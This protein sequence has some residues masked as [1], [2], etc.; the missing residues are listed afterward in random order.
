VRT[1]VGLTL[2]A[3]SI[4]QDMKTTSMTTRAD[5]VLNMKIILK[6]RWRTTGAEGCF[7]K[8]FD[9]WKEWGDD[10]PWY[11]GFEEIKEKRYGPIRTPEQFIR[12]LDA[13]LKFVLDEKRKD[14][15][16]EPPASF[17]KLMVKVKSFLDTAL[18][19]AGLAGKSSEAVL[20][21]LS[22]VKRVDK[23]PAGAR[24]PTKIPTAADV[25]FK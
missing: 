2:V 16:F 10:Y 6:R 21:A 19:S 12:W 5:Y 22:H 3:S 17:D 1:G 9:R 20:S 8:K 14:P 18:A 15:N 24:Q 13:L 11:W 4:I 25:L 23:D 7:L